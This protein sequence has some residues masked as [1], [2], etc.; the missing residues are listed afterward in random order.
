MSTEK[1]L[2]KRDQILNK[3]R[4][5]QVLRDHGPD[6]RQALLY[7]GLYSW[8]FTEGVHT[9]FLLTYLLFLP[10]TWQPGFGLPGCLRALERLPFGSQIGMWKEGFGYS[11][12]TL[13]V[14]ISNISRSL[15]G[16]EGRNKSTLPSTNP[17]YII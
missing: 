2:K 6:P 4:I 9:T 15:V 5:H 10:K 1:C 8:S 17:I 12:V 7:C 11:L 14:S 13:G 16:K 3:F